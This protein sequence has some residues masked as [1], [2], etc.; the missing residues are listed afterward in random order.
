M[1]AQ[2]E[3]DEGATENT[4]VSGAVNWLLK[5]RETPQD[6]AG[7]A[8]R[9][10]LGVQIQ[11]AQCH[12]HKTEAWK[13]TDFQSFAA[14]FVRMRVAP[15]DREK[16]MGLRRFDVVDLKRPAPRF[17]K[18]VDLA[19]ILHATPKTLLGA[20]LAGAANV[21]QAVAAWMTA[22]DN[23]WFAK[24]IVNRMW[25]H[26][27]GRGFVDPVD[28]LRPSNPGVMPELLQ[29]IA[30]DFAAHGYDTKRLIATIT[31]TEAYGL[32]SARNG[33]REIK[34]WSHFR[35]GPMG[36]EE[37]V[38]SLFAATG[39]EAMLRAARPG[40]ADRIHALVL[41]RYSFLFDVDEDADAS[42]FEGT[43]SQALTLLNGE[44]TVAG[45]E[46]LPYGGLAEVLSTPGGDPEHIDA[47][48]VRTLARH[49]TPE[50]VDHWVE[51]VNDADASPA[52]RAPPRKGGAPNGRDAL[53]RLGARG[54]SRRDPKQRA[55][56]DLFWALLN[57]T[58]FIFNH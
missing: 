51:A 31:N 3:E 53:E 20:D 43:V 2:A 28:D 33:E 8:S 1:M 10:F 19:P 35:M 54:A 41:K 37:L 4:P 40:A 49:A 36:H 9:V 11:C 22:K 38:A 50:E 45:T 29:S 46:A 25:G 18:N 5:Y 13:Q 17:A 48:Y 55:Y 21:R 52:P 44:L 15:V 26:F 27:L 6:L 32:S 12:D 24:A 7:T 34:D 23:P 14:C 42:D 57:S 47:L 39:A 30:A 16:M 58:E 56:E